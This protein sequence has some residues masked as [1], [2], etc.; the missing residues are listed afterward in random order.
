MNAIEKT[1]VEAE[2]GNF[3]DCDILQQ[4]AAELCSA[5]AAPGIS[6]DVS[7]GGQRIS[8]SAGIQNVSTQSAMSLNT[9]FR[10]GCVTKVFTSL[11]I[12]QAACEGRL[13]LDDEA[14]DHLP[15]LRG[16]PSMDG[17]KL[18][19]LMSHSSGVASPDMWDRANLERL[20]WPDH[21]IF[22]Q[23]DR[24]L[25]APGTVFSYDHIEHIVLGEIFRNVTGIAP[26][27]FQDEVLRELGLPS[28]RDLAA[29]N[30]DRNQDHFLDPESGSF[31]P[32]QGGSLSGFWDASLS[33]RLMTP[34][35]LV[36]LGEAALRRFEGTSFAAGGALLDRQLVAIPKAYGSRNAEQTPLT[37]GLGW[38]GYS[39]DVLGH[40]GSSFGQTAGLRMD[41]STG[42]VVAVGLNVWNPYIRDRLIGTILSS[43]RGRK[44]DTARRKAEMISLSEM[45][46]SY[47]NGVEGEAIEVRR[48]GK[49]LRA[50]HVKGGR[51][52]LDV[53][54]TPT[55]A[56]DLRIED[57]LH[58][59]SFGLFR[60]PATQQ[61]AIQL[62]MFAFAKVA[63]SDREPADR[64]R[65]AVI[66]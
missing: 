39:G 24:R 43:F 15:E 23:K 57:D 29:D 45:P 63:G 52:V 4:V 13:A 55:P 47:S 65:E 41:P 62:G 10:I 50:I 2:G 46:G 19:H 64:G 58:H 16:S 6:V 34:R 38:A 51:T 48:I 31:K 20:N 7:F 21:V 53:A 32:A 14:A 9:Q 3:S 18:W 12:A 40:N 36:L 54:F 35:E 44:I 60:D 28:R 26:L 49:G 56:G 42:A 17:V 22:L 37:F 25:F 27:A 11:S 1:F 33:D 59:G 61:P 5:G 8:A 30:P 66:A